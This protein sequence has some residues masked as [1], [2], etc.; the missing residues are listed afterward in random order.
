[1]KKAN[2]QFSPHIYSEWG[3]LFDSVSS[4]ERSELLLAITKFPEYE[5]KNISIWGFIKSQLQKDYEIFIAK[6]EKN[7]VISRN[8]WKQKKTNDIERL[9]NDI[10]RHPKRIT[11]T[12]N[13]N[14]NLN[15]KEN[16]KEK[17]KEI[18]KNF[19][20]FYLMYPLK[21]SKDRALQAYKKAILAAEP[22]AIMD[23]LKKYIDDI[24][25]KRTEPKFIKHPS[26]WLN[27]GCWQDEYDSFI[28]Y[29][30]PRYHNSR[31]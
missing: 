12:N 30:D 27:Q 21:K 31:L 3:E 9:P 7:G 1:M 26:T 4:D 20:E 13:L 17:E 14:L 25:I 29:S 22:S 15:K 6:C 11:K 23:G 28:D 24:R 19:N 10:E 8:Y 2:K 18:L 5:P 16:K